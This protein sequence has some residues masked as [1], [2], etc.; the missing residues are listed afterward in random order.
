MPKYH[1]DTIFDPV[2][3]HPDDAH[4]ILMRLIPARSR[5]LEL[6]CATGYLSGYMEQVLGCRVTGLEYDADSIAIART[7]CQEVYQADLDAEDALRPAQASAP[8]DV[9][10]ASA[11]LEHLKY[12]E[13]LLREAQALLKPGARVIVSLPNVAHWSMRW[14]LL[15][16]RFDYTD[17]GIL[18]RTHLHF[19][20]VS[21]G[22]TLLEGQGY[23]VAQLLIAGSG[24]QNML[25]AWARKANR[26][27]PGPILPGLLGYELIYVARVPGGG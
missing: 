8:Y 19:Y 20:T 16:G 25:N 21:T 23:P 14:R 13:R 6:G 10:L 7:R 24:L 11:V 15:C 17:Y 26:P 22:R 2:H 12:P 18:D 4:S 5:V 1:L 9:L 27:M 3:T